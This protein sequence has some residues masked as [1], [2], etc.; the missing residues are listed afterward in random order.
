MSHNNVS[1][2]TTDVGAHRTGQS[3]SVICLSLSTGRLD[4]VEREKNMFQHFIKSPTLM[5]GVRLNSNIM[6]EHY[7]RQEGHDH[8]HMFLKQ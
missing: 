7:G 1:A 6:T 8:I 4:L 5:L 3:Y 2:L